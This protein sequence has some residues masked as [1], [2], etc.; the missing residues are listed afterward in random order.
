MPRRG[1]PRQPDQ[2]LGVQRMA[3]WPD[4]RTTRHAR[5]VMECRSLCPCVPIPVQQRPLSDLT[6]KTINRDEQDGQDVILK[7]LASCCFH[8]H[9]VHPVPIFDFKFI[10][11]F[12]LYIP[13]KCLSYSRASSATG[14]SANTSARRSDGT[15]SSRTVCSK[16]PVKM[17]RYPESSPSKG[18]STRVS[19]HT[20]FPRGRR[21]P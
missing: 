4:R 3:A 11:L 5:P 6:A 13:V 10:I 18:S 1:R 16:P 19:P 15:P 21:A 9:P 7:A 8:V 14:N 2:R 20:S 12:I 17:F